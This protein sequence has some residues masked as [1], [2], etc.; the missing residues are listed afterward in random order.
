[1][2]L[3]T[4]P[5][6]NVLATREE[7]IKGCETFYGVPIS[8]IGEEGEA[9]VAIGHHEPRRYLAAMLAFARSRGWSP[10]ELDLDGLTVDAVEKAKQWRLI[11]RHADAETVGAASSRDWCVCDECE[12][13][14]VEATE[15]TPGAVAEM[16]WDVSW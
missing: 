4:C 9:V 16:W 10:S 13:W 12:W 11:Y 15:E 2:T 5:K 3:S 7:I 1:M 6:A 14:A 8:E